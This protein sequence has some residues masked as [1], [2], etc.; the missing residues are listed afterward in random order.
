VQPEEVRT[1]L[2]ICGAFNAC[3]GP[4][5]IYIILTPLGI[6]QVLPN[7]SSKTQRQRGGQQQAGMWSE[8]QTVKVTRFGT[9]R[10]IVQMQLRVFQEV[11]GKDDSGCSRFRLNCEACEALRME[12]KSMSTCLMY[13]CNLGL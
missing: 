5:S 13:A 7:R 2:Y 10:A 8:V 1:Y 9:E 6:V 4:A 12:Y 11:S 3:V